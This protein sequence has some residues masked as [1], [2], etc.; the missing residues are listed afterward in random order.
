MVLLPAVTSPTLVKKNSGSS[1]Q[2][3]VVAEDMSF[4]LSCNKMKSMRAGKV[5]RRVGL[6]EVD[7]ERSL[8]L[9]GQDDVIAALKESKIELNVNE[10]HE[11]FSP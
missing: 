11:S 10:A 7:R 9:T 3:L 2:L 5:G 4:I 1:N 8:Q 6:L